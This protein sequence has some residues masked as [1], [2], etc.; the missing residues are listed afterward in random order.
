MPNGW[1][2][3]CKDNTSAGGGASA[4]WLQKN[5]IEANIEMHFAQKAALQKPISKL[6]IRGGREPRE[7]PRIAIKIRLACNANI[8][9]GASRSTEH[10]PETRWDRWTVC[11]LIKAWLAKARKCNNI[12]RLVCVDN[13]CWSCRWQIGYCLAFRSQLASR[14]SP[15]SAFCSLLLLGHNQKSIGQVIAFP[16]TPPADCAP[17]GCQ[18]T[19]I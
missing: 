15:L 2:N 4:E 10:G 1:L 9:C 5:S 18:A 13:F 16:W 17:W 8:I 11:L 19:E 12:F 7:L 14:H 6:S 3:S